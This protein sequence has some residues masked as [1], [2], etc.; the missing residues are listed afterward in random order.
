MRRRGAFRSRALGLGT[1]VLGALCVGA[2]AVGLA[3]CGAPAETGTGPEPIPVD[4]ALVDLLADLALADARA[5]TAAPAR[6]R[7]AA[8]SL[9][10]VALAGHGV[11]DADARDQQARLARDPAVA[12]A[13]Y[14][15]AERA[16]TAARTPSSP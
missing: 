5:A 13:T 7:A 11:S 16:L 15:A 2:L 6:Q 4:S 9:R 3:G 12:R 10:V 8:E 1:L 14:D